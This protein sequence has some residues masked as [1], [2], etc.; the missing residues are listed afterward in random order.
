M[1][2]SNL[3]TVED[4]L[5]CYLTGL[6]CMADPEFSPVLRSP[7]LLFVSASVGSPLLYADE[8]RPQPDE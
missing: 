7:G 2:C 8:V 3:A 1:S 6:A 4:A 5:G